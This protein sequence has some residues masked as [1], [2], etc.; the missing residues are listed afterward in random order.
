MNLSLNGMITEPSKLIIFPL[1]VTVI[2]CQSISIISHNVFLCKD[3]FSL[4]ILHIN[5]NKWILPD[6]LHNFIGMYDL[7]SDK[8]I[9]ILIVLE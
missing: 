2:G 7:I 1:N 8:N 4:Y 6:V 3:I 9:I 5:L